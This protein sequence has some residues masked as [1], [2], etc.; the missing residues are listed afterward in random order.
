MLFGVAI[1]DRSVQELGL[2]TFEL[3]HPMYT[4]HHL[5]GDLLHFPVHGLL[6]AFQS[7]FP[8]KFATTNLAG[9]PFGSVYFLVLD[10]IC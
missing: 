9:E 5:I 4:L 1:S 2:L 3:S 7:V 8:P 6:V 10:K